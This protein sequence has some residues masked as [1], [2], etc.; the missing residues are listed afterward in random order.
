MFKQQWLMVLIVL[1]CLGML[2]AQ[3]YKGR[4]IGISS[5]GN[6]HDKDDF[7]ASAF[8]IAIVKC[9]GAKL[10]HHDYNCHIGGTTKRGE[11]EMTD[12]VLGAATLYFGDTSMCFDDQHAREAAIASIAAQINQST[13]EDMF[14]YCVGGP[15]HVPWEGIMAARPEKR[16]YCVAITHSPW[17]NKHSHNTKT[18]KDIETSGVKTVYITNQNKRLNSKQGWEWMKTSEDEKIRW[19]YTRMIKFG[20]VSDAGLAYY[21]VTGDEHGTPGKLKAL[22]ENPVLSKTYRQEA[23]VKCLFMGNWADPTVC[24]LGDTYYLTSN[25]DHYV[26]SVMVF[27]S[28]DLRRWEPLTY[29]CPSVGQG[30][31]TDIAAYDGKLYIYGGGGNGAWAMVAEPPFTQWSE[32]INM[33][34]LS[35]HGIDAGHV[36]D[37]NG[38]R[39]LHTNQGKALKISKDGLKAV[40]APE[41]VYPGWEIPD[42]LDIECVCLESPKLLKRGDWYYLVSAAGGTAGPAT[43][44]MCI[45]ARSKHVLGP[46]ENSPTNPMIWTESAEETWWTKGHGTLIEGPDGH[47]YCIYHGYA[48]HQRSF[49]RCTLISP[50][51]WTEDDWP[52]L[53][54]EWPEGW[55]DTIDVN[56]P[57]GD[58]F[59]G[60]TLTQQWQALDKLK[61]ERY[62][63]ADGSLVVDALEVEH[64]GLSYPIS[65]NPK[66]LSYEI[67]TEVTL[68]GDVTAG[69]ILYYNKHAYVSFGLSH[70]GKLHKQIQRSQSERRGPSE[71][72]ACPH[73]T[74]KLKL[75]NDRQDVSI[76]YADEAGDWV[77]LERSYDISGFQHNFFGG[78]ISVRPGLFTIGKGKASFAY[79]RYRGF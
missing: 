21:A 17:N 77:K 69:L 9:A 44:H 25:N 39:Y 5:D 7:G 11:K 49:G 23:P 38:N 46:W 76:Y 63:F 75:K 52:V 19:L 35:P 48:P 78:F 58:E 61:P 57:L 65:V 2:N 73:R 74:V 6:I 18:W 40:T 28:K 14:Y 45:V 32:R 37:E 22:F 67:E 36:A 15:M 10:V 29:A 4:R 12:S 71:T 34:P 68:T 41:V 72:L 62:G 70:E 54:A 30:P 3:T 27:T 66:H 53:A 55:E 60:E 56:W 26:P 50:I 79:F 51:A 31:A 42:S 64:P 59:D 24:K 47:W 33:E 8:S 16:Q 1:S 13:A 20:D 43:S